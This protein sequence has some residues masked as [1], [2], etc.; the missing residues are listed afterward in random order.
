MSEFN[1]TEVSV[2]HTCYYN[3]AI[4]LEHCEALGTEPNEDEYLDFIQDEINEDFPSFQYH[5]VDITYNKSCSGG[6]ITINQQI[7][8]P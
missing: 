8:T 4:Y 1:I 5:K 6:P 2:T 3:P 7:H